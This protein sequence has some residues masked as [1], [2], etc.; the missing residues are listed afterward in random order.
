MAIEEKRNV[1]RE[2]KEEKIVMI[3]SSV[4]RTCLGNMLR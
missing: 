3:S 2:D 1:Q 4:S